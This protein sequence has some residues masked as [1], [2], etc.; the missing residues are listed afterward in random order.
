MI[1]ASSSFNLETNAHSPR[2]LSVLTD[3]DFEFMNPDPYLFPNISSNIQV[4]SGFALEHQKTA[5]Q[6]LA[7]VKRLMAKH[8]STSV[9]LVSGFHM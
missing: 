9:I 8:G 2:R 4:H 5:G 6:I 3:I 7:E 1:Y